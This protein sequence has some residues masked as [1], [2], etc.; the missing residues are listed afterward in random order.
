MK[1]LSALF[2]ALVFLLFACASNPAAAVSDEPARIASDTIQEVSL[3]AESDTAEL[4][5]NGQFDENLDEWYVYLE[6]GTG[7]KTSENGELAML[8]PDAGKVAHGVQLYQDIPT[9]EE[10]CCYRLSFDMHSTV[11]RTVSVRIQMNS[12]DY[13][14]YLEE[15]IAIT[16]DTAHYDLEFQMTQASDPAPRFA[17]N[18]GSYEAD[19]ALPEHTVYLDNV[20]LTMYDDSGRIVAEDTGGKPLPININQLGYRPQDNKLAVFSGEDSSFDVVD[21]ATGAV[22]FT[23]DITGA[24]ADAASGQTTRYG[25]FSAVTAPGSY[26]IKTEKLGESFP[27]SIA[28]DVYNATFGQVLDMFYLQRC[29]SEL[30]ADTA[31]IWAH[32]AC[33]T[34][35]ATVYG[36][37]LKLD[38][39]GGWHDAG[40]YGRYSAAGAKAAADLLLAY[41]LNPQAFANPVSS[42]IPGIIDEV[43]YELEWLL[44][45]QDSASGGVYHKVTT[46]NFAGEVMPDTVTEELILSPI[47]VTASA[48]FAAVMAM[49]STV[50]KPYDAA[51]AAKCLVAAEKAWQFAASNPY[52]L[53]HNP[54]GIV[55]GEYG[56][57]VSSDERYWAACELLKATGKQEYNEYVIK[58]YQQNIPAGLGWASVGTYGSYAYL[59]TSQDKVD[60]TAAQAVRAALIQGSQQFVEE[61]RT[62]GY[63]ISLGTSYPWG[64]NMNV[65]NNAMQLLLTDQIA[66]DPVYAQVAANHLHYL[67]GTNCLSYSYVTGSSTQSPTHTHHRPS[68]AMEETMPGMLVGG[69]NNRLED[70]YARAVLKE[71]APA[72]CYADNAQCFSTNEI[73][74]YWN[75]P[76]VFLMSYFAQ[77]D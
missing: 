33:H 59:T 34:S 74:I 22:V 27:F 45:M 49:A 53:F 39:S 16:A 40:D 64:S 4:I 73:T 62:D 24:V 25:D 42:A 5:I 72:Q 10:G 28:E 60:D 31:G 3:P 29:G 2:F 38:V 68:M 19:G 14:G 18:M 54:E 20:S 9:I 26:H 44:K 76:L 6:G 1:R 8:I 11:P 66:P 57:A 50:Y 77:I 32:A 67:F 75:S 58:V 43:R 47:S 7:E 17:I 56:D 46:A 65:A 37:D 13:Y 61:S 71:L 23:G 35:P 41:Q 15:Q 48:D 51:F 63:L 69:P 36:T 70:P 12:G 21:A 30:S 55:T 52:M